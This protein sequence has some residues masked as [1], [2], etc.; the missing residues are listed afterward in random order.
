MDEIKQ[1]NEEEIDVGDSED[2][3]EEEEE[4]EEDLGASPL[5]D[6]GSLMMALAS[7]NGRPKYSNLLI[8][9]FVVS[10]MCSFVEK[11][12]CANCERRKKTL[13][14]IW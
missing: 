4:E 2:A 5:G 8:K 11:K 10:E 9:V 12:Y 1:T 3:E 13:A 6:H 14:V 7:T